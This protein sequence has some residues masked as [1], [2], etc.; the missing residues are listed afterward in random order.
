MIDYFQVYSQM[1]VNIS[2]P[3]TFNYSTIQKKLDL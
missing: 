3:V 1:C 2:I